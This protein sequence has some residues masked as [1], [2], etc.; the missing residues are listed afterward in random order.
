[1]NM[2][3]WKLYRRCKTMI[4]HYLF[5]GTLL[6]IISV[7]LG[8]TVTNERIIKWLIL[9]V[10]TTIAIMWDCAKGYYKYVHD[11]FLKKIVKKVFYVCS[12]DCSKRV[13]DEEDF[14]IEKI[15]FYRIKRVTISCY[16]E[17]QQSVID[18][19]QRMK[20]IKAPRRKRKCLTD[21]SRE[22]FECFCVPICKDLRGGD[23]IE[24]SY[25][26]GSNTVVDLKILPKEELNVQLC[27]GKKNKSV[28]EEEKHYRLKKIIGT[29]IFTGIS[30]CIY[31]LFCLI[32]VFFSI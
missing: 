5:T 22:R 18:H 7:V 27:L 17:Y 1:M 30:V 15:R 19:N 2:S 16:N 23:R 8:C 13:S 10:L 28:V 6:T 12:V 26:K 3:R 24:I 32:S 9:V 4:N 29:V 21:V 31:L 20:E 14:V 11:I 25:L